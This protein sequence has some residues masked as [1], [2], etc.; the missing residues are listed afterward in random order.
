[1]AL[2]DFCDCC[3]AVAGIRFSG[4]HQLSDHPSAALQLSRQIHRKYYQSS[5]LPLEAGSDT[6]STLVAG[7]LF[8]WEFDVFIRY[9]VKYLSCGLT[10]LINCNKSQQKFQQSQIIIQCKREFAIGEYDSGR[11]HIYLAAAAA[12]AQNPVI[13]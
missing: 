3:D 5:F 2:V 8:T 1:M 13:N 11:P 6:L 10:K 7:I 9:Y 4:D 12:V